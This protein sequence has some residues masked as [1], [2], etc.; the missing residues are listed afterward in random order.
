M[1]DV[2]RAGGG[3]LSEVTSRRRRERAPKPIRFG[4]IGLG[5]MGQEHARVIA[6]NPLLD[7]VAATDAQ[8]SSGRKVAADLRCKWFDSAEEMIRSGEVDG[9]RDC[10]AA[11]DARRAGD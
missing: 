3:S 10:N 5:I 8:A 2:A 7:L 11:L 1:R 4:V 9:G 6:A